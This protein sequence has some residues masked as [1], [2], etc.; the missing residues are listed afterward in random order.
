MCAAGA[1]AS[2]APL[3]Q[4]QQQHQQPQLPADDDWLQRT[5]LLVGQEGLDKLAALNVLLVGLGGV[6]S[7]AA[8]LL[9]RAGVGA[10]TIVVSCSLL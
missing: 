4:Q 7:F 2:I 6:G 1:G 3:E 5:R 9:C 10:M 8:E